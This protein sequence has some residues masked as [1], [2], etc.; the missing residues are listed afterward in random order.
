MAETLY[1][2][3]DDEGVVT[4]VIV[5]DKAFIDSLGE[6][7]EDPDVDTGDLAFAKAYDVT[8][9]G[10]GI[11]HK[12]AA[13]GK[14]VAPAPPAPPEPTEDELAAQKAAQAAAD[15]RAADDEFLDGLATKLNTGGSLTQDERD[16]KDV[17]LARRG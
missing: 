11:G 4:N 9:K 15:Q 6:Q 17:I 8:D 16:R 12:R 2:L 3:V 14:W 10:V 13:N 5:A 1:A 7:I